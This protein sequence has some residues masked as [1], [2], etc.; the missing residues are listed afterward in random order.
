MSLADEMRTLADKMQKDLTFDDK[1][2]VIENIRKQA[3][4]GKYEHD[5]WCVGK[6][7]AAIAYMNE[8]G[9]TILNTMYNDDGDIVSIRVSWRAK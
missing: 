9:F 5:F 8:L 6:G 3:M 4:A 1:H 2:N 7:K